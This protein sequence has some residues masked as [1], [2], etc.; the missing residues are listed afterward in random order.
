MT[1]Y[2][3]YRLSGRSTDPYKTGYRVGKKIVKKNQNHWKK[4]MAK[5]T[6]TEPL[7]DV[8]KKV[9]AKIFDLGFSNE[10]KDCEIKI[11]TIDQKIK[12]LKQD[13]SALTTNLE[14]QHQE[15]KRNLLSEISD[16]EKELARRQEEYRKLQQ[17]QDNKAPIAQ[18]DKQPKTLNRWGT[19][20]TAAKN[21]LSSAL[22]NVEMDILYYFYLGLAVLLF[23]GDFFITYAIFSDVL[24]VQVGSTITIGFIAVKSAY[25][26]SAIIALV[27]V[28]LVDFLINYVEKRYRNS[29]H[30]I[31]QLTLYAILGIGFLLLLAYVLVI[32]VPVMKGHESVV[33][34]AL[35]R[36]LFVPLVFAVGLIL[37]KIRTEHRFNFIFTPFKIVLLPLAMI[38]FGILMVAELILHFVIGLFRSQKPRRADTLQ[39][40]TLA[41]NTTELN[42]KL[43]THKSELEHL[44]RNFGN[45]KDT[46]ITKINVQITSLEQQ[47]EIQGSRLRLLR[48]GSDEAV[49]TCLTIS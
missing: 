36:I 39:E 8:I 16:L 46:M 4:Q 6:E 17:E 22:A 49:A 35:L 28:T 32:L 23:I 25:I 37:H 47:K 31:N 20:I 40:L 24:K 13:I 45:K 7:E 26:F 34:D 10:T 41:K 19:L 12:E 9:Q 3:L 2:L 27:F 14:N 30:V 29:V 44:D 48:Q 18:P 21:Q 11:E 33:I 38:V 5:A 15:D 42:T 1:V 43:A